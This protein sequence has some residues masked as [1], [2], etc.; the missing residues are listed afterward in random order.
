MIGTIKHIHDTGAYRYASDVLEEKEP[1]GNF[2]TLAAERFIKDVERKDIYMDLVEA[3]K[4]VNFAAKCKHWKGSFAGK[5]IELLPHQQFYFQQMYGWKYTDSQLRRFKRSAKLV[6]RK[7]GKTTEMAV[8]GMYHVLVDEPNGPQVWIGATKKDQAKICLKDIAQIIKKSDGLKEKF[9]IFWN[10]DKPTE[11]LCN[12]SDGLMS[13]I[14]R[15]SDTEDGLDVSMIIIDEWHAHKDTSVRDIL[16]SA[17]GNRMQPME[18]I[19]STAGFNM[20]GPCYTKTRKVGIDILNGIKQDDE[21]LVLFYEINQDQWDDWE[22]Q[23]LWAHANPNM[24][25]SPT[26]LRSIESEYTKAKNEGGTTEV[27]FKTKHLNIWTSAADR[28]LDIEHIKKCNHGITEDELQ[29]RDCY[30]GLDLS[31]GTDLNALA[32]FFPNVRP[33][34][35]AVK[36]KYWIPSIKVSQRQDEVDYY[37]WVQAGWM[38]QFEGNGVDYDVI[39]EEAIK[40]C[41]GYNLLGMAADPSHLYVGPASHWKGTGMMDMLE[42]WPQTYTNLT[43]ATEQ[44]ETWVSK[45]QMEFFGNPV[46]E[47]NISNVTLSLGVSAGKMPSKGRSIDRI[48]GVAAMVNSVAKFLKDGAEP[49]KGEVFVLGV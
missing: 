35:H 10:K 7:N 44:V 25:V 46:L 8:Q 9:R 18:S 40:F 11:I 36:M 6:A 3:R 49:P 4:I 24:H 12:P 2:I 33:D 37:Q 26:I 41:E 17:T 34:I 45:Y 38:R 20:Q 48:D 14:G 19:I 16:S 32:L 13:V 1:V 29:G 15:D 39:A 5:P 43:P 47:W 27:N 23:D 31:G 22:N 42:V 28:W 30:A 21:Q